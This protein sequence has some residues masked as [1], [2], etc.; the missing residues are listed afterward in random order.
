MISLSVFSGYFA[1][2]GRNPKWDYWNISLINT[3]KFELLPSSSANRGLLIIC[4]FSVNLLEILHHFLFR[5][6]SYVF[7]VWMLVN[8]SVTLSLVSF[9][10]ISFTE[11]TAAT[12]LQLKGS[13]LLIKG[14]KGTLCP[15]WLYRGLITF[16]LQ[17]CILLTSFVTETRA[18]SH[19]YTQHLVPP[20]RLE[21][22]T[23]SVKE[24]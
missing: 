23:G 20:V 5:W 10:Y 7:I 18:H 16:S 21:H 8:R 19:K 13:P 22:T 3:P 12:V 14:K 15:L 2:L 9:L 4:V 11:S 6:A 1:S 17:G 24:H